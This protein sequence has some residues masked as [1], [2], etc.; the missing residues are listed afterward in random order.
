[1]IND[2]GTN[3]DTKT[4]SPSA[5]RV[6]DRKARMRGMADGLEAERRKVAE[7]QMVIG[8]RNNAARSYGRGGRPAPAAAP[9]PTAAPAPNGAPPGLIFLPGMTMA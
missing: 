2:A 1:M 7:M 8:R 3:V 9:A 6:K 4:H 5:K